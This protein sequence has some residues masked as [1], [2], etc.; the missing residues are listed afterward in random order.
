MATNRN[1]LKAIANP[2]ECP[3]VG[4]ALTITA[5][6]NSHAG[7]VFRDTQDR[8]RLLHLAFHHD[9]KH[10]A[11]NRVEY[12]C[13][14]PEF[15]AV[16]A[17]IV[18]AHCRLI[19]SLAPNINFAIHHNP[20]AR[21]KAKG[22]TVNVEHEDKG[23]NCS[24]F[25]LAVFAEAGPPLVDFATWRT[26]DTDARWH[27]FL[28]ALLKKHAPEA[29]WKKV[30]QDIGCARV[31]PEEVAGACLENPLPATFEQ[32]EANGVFALGEVA[33]HVGRTSIW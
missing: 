21:L 31:R 7:I 14:D 28:V 32:C 29:H 26:R 19:A 23:L 1:R 24:T 15:D 11:F 12:L 13:A 4:V 25:V 30:E 18:A 3:I 8:V 6:R 33:K 17:E 9:L 2:K 5:N 22:Q 10:E 20:A 27:R 16:D